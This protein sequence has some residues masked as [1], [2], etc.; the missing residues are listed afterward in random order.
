MPPHTTTSLFLHGG[1]GLS[2]IAER[3]A[4]GDDL[5]IYWWDQPRAVM[6]TPRPFATLVS[7]ALDQLDAL[8]RANGGPVPVIAHSF[9]VNLA[10][11]LALRQPNAIASLELLAPV[12]DLGGAFIQLAARLAAADTTQA[13]RLRDAILTYENG[14]PSIDATWALIV[15][16]QSTPDFLS[17][18]WSKAAQAP[19]KRFVELMAR[20][21]VFDPAAYEAIFK[22]FTTGPVASSMSGCSAPVHILFG[23]VDPLARPEHDFAWWRRRFPNAMRHD[24]DAGHFIQLETLPATWLK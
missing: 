21:P 19:H 23:T 17:A 13:E 18:Y 12:H 11:E 9:G 20:E 10:Y 1:P 3:D 22:D 6:H 24:V 14:V 7:A 16:V 15:A 2:C 8:R 4:Y 5:P